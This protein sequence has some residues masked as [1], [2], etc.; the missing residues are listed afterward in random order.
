MHCEGK[1]KLRSNTSSYCL[2]DMVT[3]AGLTVVKMYYDK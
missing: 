2:I 1:Q 3:K